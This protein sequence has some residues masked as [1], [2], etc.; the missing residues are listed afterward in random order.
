[1]RGIVAGVCLGA[2]VAATGLARAGALGASGVVVIPDGAPYDLSSQ[3]SLSEPERQR[4]L[5][6]FGRYADVSKALGLGTVRVGATPPEL[7][8]WG[9][10]EP[11]P[12]SYR[13]LVADLLVESLVVRGLEPV[14]PLSS[15]ADWDHDPSTLLP[16]DKARFRDYV[17]L[18]V[19]RYDGDL[20]FGVPPGEEYP[21]VTGDGSVSIADW[22]APES[23]R[24]A[25]AD[26][27]VVRWWEVVAEGPAAEVA[28][29]VQLIRPEARAASPESLLLIAGNAAGPGG[30]GQLSERLGG[31]DPKLT[32]E[33]LVDAVGF[34]V[35]TTGDGLAALAIFDELR[36][37]F[38]WVAAIG[39]QDAEVWITSIGAGA[40]PPPDGQAGPCGDPR[41]DEHTQAAQLVKLM[42]QALETMPVAVPGGFEERRFDRVLLREPVEHGASPEWAGGGVLT[43]TEGDPATDPMLVRPAWAA[44]ARVAPVLEAAAPDGVER[45][46]LFPDNEARRIY[47]VRTPEGLVSHVA[48]YN[49]DMDLGAAA[50]DGRFL[51]VT[52]ADVQGTAKVTTLFPSSID[53]VTGGASVQWM[54]PEVLVAAEAGGVTI[55][56]RQEALLVEPVTDAPAPEDAGPVDAADA[57]ASEPDIAAGSDVAPSAPAASDDGCGGPG[58]LPPLALLLLWV[59]RRRPQNR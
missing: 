13:F 14:L 40:L 17:R 55:D 9:A 35:P 22:G 45:L 46:I 36:D 20:D 43:F 10:V 54:L 21:D 3:T 1:M 25:W 50:Y 51:K 24:Q 58:A 29:L 49:W 12:N 33:R 38:G 2:A 15:R 48:W 52:L 47:A 30:K 8:S 18:L 11:E 5:S 26:A 27:H 7:F 34:D 44:V 19:E 6:L 23:V 42:V 57:S 39:L 59:P 28:P 53:E 31:L 16:D 4:W 41:C 32:G 37:T 56:I